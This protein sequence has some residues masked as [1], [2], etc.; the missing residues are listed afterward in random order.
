MNSASPPDDDRSKREAK[1]IDELRVDQR[2][3]EVG[4]ASHLQFVTG[5]SFSA[6]TDSTTS[7]GSTVRFQVHCSRAFVTTY[8]GSVFIRTVNG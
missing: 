8:F 6:P 5:A 4:A 1:T 2:G 7:R 3:R